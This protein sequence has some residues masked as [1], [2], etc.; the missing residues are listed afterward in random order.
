MSFIDGIPFAVYCNHCNGT[1]F[2]NEHE[3]HLSMPLHT[4]S[5]HTFIM[6]FSWPEIVEC[7]C[8]LC[9]RL[10]NTWQT[11]RISVPAPYILF[12]KVG[13]GDMALQEQIEIMKVY[14]KEI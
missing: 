2:V 12:H 7:R 5:I 13:A 3:L 6:D 10:S 14:L 1:A 4:N 11:T 8:T 9:G